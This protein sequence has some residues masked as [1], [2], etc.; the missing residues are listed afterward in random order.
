MTADKMR[1]KHSQV[2][3]E[4]T[5]VI[6]SSKPTEHLQQ[7]QECTEL[8]NC[9]EENS[10]FVSARTDDLQ[11]SHTDS[12]QVTQVTREQNVTTEA[13][14]AVTHTQKHCRQGSCQSTCARPVSRAAATAKLPRRT[15]FP[16][17]Q[18]SLSA[19]LPRAALLPRNTGQSHAESRSCQADFYELCP[20]QEVINEHGAKSAHE[21]VLVYKHPPFVT[22][23]Q[24][25]L[26]KVQNYRTTI[27]GM[28]LYL[29]IWLY[30][31][32]IYYFFSYL[33]AGQMHST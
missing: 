15:G 13:P 8:R 7:L 6:K 21:N 22:N 17:V 18:H 23:V 2:C 33:C 14:A 20:H 26:C 30:M 5:T 19:S 16:L 4:H 9:L 25:T 32:H 12:S 3:S 29:N 28:S 27:L 1:V 31:Y 11:S 24:V 10:L